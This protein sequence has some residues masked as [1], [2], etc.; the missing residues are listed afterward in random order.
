[1]VNI[2]YFLNYMNCKNMYL[3]VINNSGKRSALQINYFGITYLL[4][5]YYLKLNFKIKNVCN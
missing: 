5:M 3:V 2:H 1:M 4:T